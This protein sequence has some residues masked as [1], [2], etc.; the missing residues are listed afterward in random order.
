MDDDFKGIWKPTS[1]KP[2]D[3]QTVLVSWKGYGGHYKGPYRAY[4]VDDEH[5]FFSVDDNH[6]IPLKVDIWIEIPEFP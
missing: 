3:D 1:I 5:N 4:Y 6:A 2:K